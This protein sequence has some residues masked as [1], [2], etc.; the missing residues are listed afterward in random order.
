MEKMKRRICRLIIATEL[1]QERRGTIP[2]ERVLRIG[3]VN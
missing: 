2:L 1:E 3:T